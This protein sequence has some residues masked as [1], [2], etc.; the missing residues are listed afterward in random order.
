MNHHT[1]GIAGFLNSP[2]LR[3][4]IA[5]VPEKGGTLAPTGTRPTSDVLYPGCKAFANAYD[6]LAQARESVLQENFSAATHQVADA[7]NDFKDWTGKCGYA[8]TANPTQAQF[9]EDVGR[10]RGRIERALA[11]VAGIHLRAEADTSELV[12]GNTFHVTPRTNCRQASGQFS[13]CSGS[14]CAGEYVVIVAKGQC[15]PW[16]RI[17]C[18]FYRERSGP[19]EQ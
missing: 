18:H 15:G 14:G 6:L 10:S 2:F 12:P 19:S 9:L 4:P 13:W 11:L 5:L 3:R 7:A 1:Q 16:L 17:H 8:V